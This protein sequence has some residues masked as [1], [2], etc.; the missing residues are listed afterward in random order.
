MSR[1]Q[2]G[3]KAYLWCRSRNAKDSSLTIISSKSTSLVQ[4]WD[5]RLNV[6]P[7]C[8]VSDETQKTEGKYWVTSTGTSKVRGFLA[9]IGSRDVSSG[10]Q[11]LL[12]D[13]SPGVSVF[14]ITC[15]GSSAHSWS[16]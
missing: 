4:Y 11:S 10:V 16:L 1:L 13:F 12:T 5:C 14:F 15:T 2:V 3:C 6:R 7:V 8:S 9:Q